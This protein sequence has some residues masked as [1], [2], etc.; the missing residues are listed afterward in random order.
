M[1][2]AIVELQCTDWMDNLKLWELVVTILK[3]NRAFFLFPLIL[4]SVC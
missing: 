4:T 3:F 2:I 1:C